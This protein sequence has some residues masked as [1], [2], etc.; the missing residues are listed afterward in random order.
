MELTKAAI[1]KLTLPETGYAFERDGKHPGLG[2]R[3]SNKGSMSWILERRVAGKN[4]RR[5]LGDANGPGALSRT[6][7]ITEFKRVD[8]EL[9]AGEDRVAAR[10][11][12]MATPATPTFGAALREYVAGKRRKD[13][14][15]LK[16]RTVADYLA[17]IEP[18]RALLNGKATRGGELHLIADKPLSALHGD[19]IRAVHA[20]AGGSRRQDYAMQVLRAVLNWHG[21]VIVPD[22]PLNA[23]Q[24]GR[25]RITIGAAKVAKNPIPKENL[26]AWWNA[27]GK[28]RSQTAG[29]A[30]KALLLS[31]CRPVE[32]LGDRFGNE[33]LRVRNVDFKAGTIRLSNTKNRKGHAVYLST[34]L[35]A[36]LARRCEGLQADDAVFPIL[37]QCKLPA[38]PQGCLQPPTRRATPAAPSPASPLPWSLTAPSRRC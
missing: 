21:G 8:H 24:P 28:I 2:I 7:A 37:G 15:A 10:K 1:A 14:L 33:P 16:P 29:D 30:L 9:E 35:Q 19:D 12:T 26:G 23:D 25:K 36:I 6:E 13:K 17:M 22:S 5:T 32:F 20:A 18:P 11:A 4:V 27:C 38:G 31:G 3:I 34:E